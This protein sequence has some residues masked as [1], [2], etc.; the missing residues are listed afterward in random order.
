MSWSGD[1]D[2]RLLYFD[3]ILS[4]QRAKR[5][6]TTIRL[7]R[8]DE[9]FLHHF[10]SNPIVP[11]SFLIECFAQGATAL[12]EASSDFRLKAFPVFIREA[13]FRRPTRPG[14]NIHFELQ[15]QQWSDEG[16]LLNGRALQDG[17]Q[18]AS[19]LL[20]MATAPIAEFYRNP[21]D[22]GLLLATY[23]RWLEDAA[24]A[25]FDPPLAEILSHALAD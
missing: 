8:D 15:V 5:I 2:V 12:L 4:M 13:K 17:A 6:E 25:D 1:S 10:P 16:A 14:S 20:G 11:A 23:E 24:L 18:A 22:R 7:A 19:C 21:A 3:R 9:L